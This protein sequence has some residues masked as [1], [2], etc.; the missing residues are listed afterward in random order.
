MT[1][2][3]KWLRWAAIGAAAFVLITALPWRTGD[4]R[5]D[6]GR[7]TPD[8]AEEQRLK[9]AAVLRDAEM[10]AKLCTL[11]C[12]AKLGALEADADET[13]IRGMLR[14]HPHMV[15][16]RLRTE[17]GKVTEAGAD[18]E[19]VKEQWSGLLREAERAARTGRTFV[20]NPVTSN[21]KRHIVLG[22]PAADGSGTVSGIIRQDIVG[23]VE[24]SQRRNLRLVPYPAEGRYKTESV[25]PN[26]TRDITVR[27]GEDNGEASHYVI[28]E[29]VVR[30]HREPTD[31]EMQSIMRSINGASVRKL[32]YAYVFTSHTM[33]A[34]E[35]IDYFRKRDDIVYAEPHY[36]YVTNDRLDGLSANGFRAH[37]ASADEGDGPAVVPND[38]LYKTYQWN[39]PA[40]DTENGWSLSRGSEDIVIAV[41]DT[42]VQLDHPEL[43]GRLVEGVNLISEGQPSDDVGHGTHVAGII[44]AEVNNGEGIAGMSWH[45]RI[46]PVKVLDSTGAGSAY[47]VAEGIIWATDHGA[48]VI[49]M[50]LGNYASAEFLHDAIRY[51]YDRG[52]VLVAA[53]GNDNTER[54]GYPAAYPEV[55]AV[56]ATD[57]YNRKA[58]F[59]NYGDYIDAAAPGDAIA[60]TY[61][62][63]RYAA[64]SG[65]SMASPHAAALAGLILSVNPDLSNEDVM[66][67][68]RSTAIDLGDKGR[69]IYYGYGLIDVKRALEAAEQSAHTLG[70]FRRAFE[71]RIEAIRRQF[72]IEPPA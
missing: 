1:N 38:A 14:K 49:N 15:Y 3:A 54:P 27:S 60:S 69:D 71:Q 31:A 35:L 61:P 40:I 17:G 23:E 59:S 68:M 56:A 39:L 66:E 21:G 42:G 47:A 16:V 34:D 32:G 37:D 36:L 19:A 6:A 55:F 52:V 22:V 20:S 2:R 57:G 64:M 8:P 62:G 33:E 41:L 70:G 4:E 65:T 28:N 50:S 25:E 13:V 12:S 58:P 29:A 26:T 44:A 9:T 45:N 10:T 51:A 67:I 24:R 7:Q 72:G 30:F 43:A 18:A 48:D 46:M 5:E 11:D 63:S 53:S